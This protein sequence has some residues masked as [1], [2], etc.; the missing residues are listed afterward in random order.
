MGERLH[1]AADLLPLV[2]RWIDRGTRS[3]VVA[4]TFAV[5]A[6]GTGVLLASGR[7]IAFA[8]APALL[9]VLPTAR[10]SLLWWTLAATTAGAAV[11]VHRTAGRASRLA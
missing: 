5:R 9:A 3:R 11:V 1:P 8:V 2:G 10:P 6:A 7:P 4:G